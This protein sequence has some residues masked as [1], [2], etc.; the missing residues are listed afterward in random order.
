[1]PR[2]STMPGVPSQSWPTSTSRTVSATT[3]KAVLSWFISL[4]L[5]PPELGQSGGRRWPPDSLFSGQDA[6][7]GSLIRD[8]DLVHGVVVR[9]GGVGASF[10][11]ERLL[12]EVEQVAVGARSEAEDAEVADV[13]DVHRGRCHLAHRPR[14]RRGRSRQ[15]QGLRGVE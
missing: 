3:R 8:P 9:V 5:P 11:V 15:V 2:N 6:R 14:G 7:S 1:M 12:D 10:L 13:S 4:I